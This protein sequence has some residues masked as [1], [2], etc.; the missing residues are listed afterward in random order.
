MPWAMRI[1]TPECL[2]NSRLHFELFVRALR[3]RVAQNDTE[4][5]SPKGLIFKPD[6]DVGSIRL[7]QM[8]SAMQDAD[9]DR[10]KK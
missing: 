6:T 5:L 2:M 7:S 1:A 4:Q 9:A 8:Q 10:A 3:A